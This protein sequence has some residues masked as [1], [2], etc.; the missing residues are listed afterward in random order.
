MTGHSG[1]Y[2]GAQHSLPVIP[3]AGWYAGVCE[4]SEWR[5]PSRLQVGADVQL[6]WPA[7]GRRSQ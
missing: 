5:A 7:S 2:L 4:R 1:L 3:A 6:C